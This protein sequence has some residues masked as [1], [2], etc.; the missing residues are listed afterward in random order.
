MM[1][2]E[3][4]NA[5]LNEQITEEFS[6]GQKYLAMACAFDT[7]GLKIMHQRFLA[8]AA[9]ERDHAMRILHY[10]HEVGGIVTLDKLPKPSGEFSSLEAIVQAALESEEQI[11]RMVNELVALAESEKD[12][13]TRS[14]LQWFVTEQVE[15]VSSMRDLLGLVRMAGRDMLQVEARVRHEM[16]Q[17][18]A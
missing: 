2:S 12:Y 7:M 8:Q 15:E 6:A 17:Q 3:T 1:I 10:I 5:R 13:A 11:T 14:F 9:E 4:M 18:P 16:M